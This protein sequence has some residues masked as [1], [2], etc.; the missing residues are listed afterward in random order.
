M[1]KI[2]W[3]MVMIFS[4]VSCDS[5]GP[6]FTPDVDLAVHQAQWRQHGIHDYMFDFTIAGVWIAPPPVRHRVRL[7][8]EDLERQV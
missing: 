7:G 4:V 3:T 5:V 6:S 8:T 2:C 1:H